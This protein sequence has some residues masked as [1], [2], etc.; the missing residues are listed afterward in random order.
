MVRSE[1]LDAQ[2]EGAGGFGRRREDRL[3]YKLVDMHGG[4]ELISW[5][6][7]YGAF[8][9]VDDQKNHRADLPDEESVQLPLKTNYT[10]RMYFGEFPLSFA[11]CMN[12]EDCFRLL[13]AYKA[14]PNAQDSNG[15]T[16]LHMCVIH[17][18][19]I[20]GMEADVIW[21]YADSS[22][23][24]YPLAKIDTINE[25]NGE[26]NEQSALALVVYGESTDHLELLDGLL[27]SII[28]SKWIAY[29][30]R[31][32][33]ISLIS[34]VIYYIFLVAA[35]SLRPISMTTSALTNQ[36]VCETG[37][38]AND[39]WEWEKLDPEIDWNT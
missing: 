35:F 26:L 1:P 36:N 28:E 18:N 4:G 30:R 25:E 22:Q 27:E 13:I 5:M 38:P 8:F 34:F 2:N 7:C 24:A 17:E 19:L 14:N 39:I 15:N 29:G 9:C 10:G 31:R 21:S 33:C 6:R 11:A 32:W 20:L 23:T 37:L 16:V 12:D 3:M